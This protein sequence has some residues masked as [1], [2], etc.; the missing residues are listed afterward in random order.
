MSEPTIEELEAA[1]ERVEIE[2]NALGVLR[3]SITEL[4]KA[5]D[6]VAKQFGGNDESQSTQSE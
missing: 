6:D 2:L 3:E 1:L 4:S 5:I